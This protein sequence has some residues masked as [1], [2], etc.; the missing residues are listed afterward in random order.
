MSVY[1]NEKSCEACGKSMQFDPIGEPFGA[2]SFYGIKERY[3]ER[4]NVSNRIFPK[5]ENKKSEAAKSYVRKLEK[6]FSDLIS[7]FNSNNPIASDRS[8]LFYVESLELIDELLRYDVSSDLIQAL[9]IEND[10]SLIGQKLLFHLHDESNAMKAESSWQ[11]LFLNY[12]FWGVI[13][14]ES[15]LKFF[16]ITTTIVIMAVKYKDIISSQFGK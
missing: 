4:L 9:L 12:R 6:R 8:K 13:K 15:F 5:L 2:K 10:G 14:V 3:I 7:S 1:I 11:E 16:I